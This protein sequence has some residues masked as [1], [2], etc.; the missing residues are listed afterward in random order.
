[1]RARRIRYR[2]VFEADPAREPGAEDIE[3]TSKVGGY[4]GWLQGEAVPRCGT[5][6]RP[7]RFL[8][9]LG[10]LDG[11]MNFGGGDGYLFCC[12]SEHQ[13]KFLWQQ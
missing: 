9:Q 13:A 10:E 3:A 12:P 11:Q 2:E 7:M 6:R 5:C 1:M 8:A 4:P